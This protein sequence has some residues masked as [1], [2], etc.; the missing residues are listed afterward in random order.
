MSRF[1]SA[2][3]DALTPYVPGEQPGERQYV[4]LN[5]NEN[6]FPPSPE[7]LRYA[8]EHTRSQE[9]YSDP[10]GVELRAALARTYGV[11]PEETVL[12]NGSDEV[13][14][15]AFMAFCDESRPA[16]FPDI[17]Y[18]FYPVFA[19]LNRVPY[20]ELPL[21]EDFTLD[22][23]DYRDR[24]GTL[25]IANPNAPTGIL[26]PP[27]EIEALLRARRDRLVVVDEAYVDFGGES[28][29]PLIHDYDNL[30]VIQTFSK[31]RS[32]AGARLGFG[33]ACESLIR[34]LNT[35]RYSTNPYNVNSMTL[36]L[37]LGTLLDPE[38]TKRNCAEIVRVR[39]E[40]AERLRALGF[41]LTESRANFLFARSKRIGGEALYRRLKDRGILVRHFDKPRIRDYNRITVG[42]PAQMEAL[43]TAIQSILEET[44]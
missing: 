6:P 43:L 11:R 27:A 29:V 39:E 7:A 21:R 37:G 12:V 31:S 38:Y 44:T 18:G 14:N 34:D 42:T 33:I 2:K 35:I 24:E 16:L 32:M 30:L 3:Y 25:F 19:Q 9:L 5:T 26:L 23:A 8:A 22:P 15:F 17:T 41:T 28:C 36:A 10:E 20:E 4:K 13:L 40:T 1:F